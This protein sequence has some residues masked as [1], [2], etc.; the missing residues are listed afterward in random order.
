MRR[1]LIEAPLLLTRQFNL[2]L[3]EVCKPLQKRVVRLLNVVEVIC[4]DVFTMVSWVF[5]TTCHRAWVVQD[6]P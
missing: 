4:M 2:H 1:T 3:L 5:F 6:R